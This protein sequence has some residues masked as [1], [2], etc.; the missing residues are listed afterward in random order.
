[1]SA[2]YTYEMLKQMKGQAVKDIWHAMIGKPAGLKNTTGLKNTDEIIQ[3]ILNRQASPGDDPPKQSVARQVEPQEMP[4][5]KQPIV[6]AVPLVTVKS[7]AIESTEIP[8][9]VE[10][11][12]KRLVRKLHVGDTCYFLDGTTQEVFQNLD[13]KPGTLLGRW[14][15][16]ERRVDAI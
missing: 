11:V 7:M 6:K 5:K 3:A 12:Q 15:A 8:L 16:D 1:M 10:E 4:R 14:N 2:S 13:G 9:V